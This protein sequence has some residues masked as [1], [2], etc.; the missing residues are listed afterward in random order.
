[1]SPI[2]FECRQSLPHAPLAICENIAD[3]TRWAEFTG[4]GPLPG[5][6]SAAYE[7]RTPNMVGSRIRVQNKDGSGHVEEIYTWQPEQAVGMK[8][9][10]FTPPL[11]HL[12]T[13]FTED[14]RFRWEGNMTHV[15]RS[16]QLFPTRPT[17]R[18]VLWL[19]SLLFRRAIA[20]HLADMA[21]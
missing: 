7:T 10:E 13:H 19:I 20:R 2:V 21:A 11:R 15:T 8:L 16:F 9:H 3:L 18:P 5:I 12:A 17:T 6:A 14:W 4:Y 1:M